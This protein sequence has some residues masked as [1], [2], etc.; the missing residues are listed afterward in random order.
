MHAHLK[1][2]QAAGAVEVAEGYCPLDL[3]S[4]EPARVRRALEALWDAWVRS[5]GAVN[6]LRVFVSGAMVRP[7]AEDPTS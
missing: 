3:Y 6:S 1:R 2:T 7:R 4:G 5:G